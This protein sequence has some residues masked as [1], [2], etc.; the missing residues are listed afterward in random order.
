MS[1][2]TQRSNC[3]VR[4]LPARSKPK[5]LDPRAYSEFVICGRVGQAENHVLTLFVVFLR[6]RAIA[7]IKTAV[8]RVSFDFC[9]KAHAGRKVHFLFQVNKFTTANHKTKAVAGSFQ[10]DRRPKLFVDLLD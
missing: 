5:K 3:S 1:I 7:H 4:F 6:D 10:D 8:P 9:G 2:C